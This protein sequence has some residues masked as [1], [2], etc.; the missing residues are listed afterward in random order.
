MSKWS[1]FFVPSLCKLF[2]G[3]PNPH[4]ITLGSAKCRSLLFTAAR[5]SL[6]VAFGT[7]LIAQEPPKREREVEKQYF[8]H[9]FLNRKKIWTS[10]VQLRSRPLPSRMPLVAIGGG[11]ST[12]DSNVAEQLEGNHLFAFGEQNPASSGVASLVGGAAFYLYGRFVEE[13]HSRET[14]VFASVGELNSI[15]VSEG[16]KLATGRERPFE[17]A[18]GRFLQG[19]SSFP[20]NHPFLR[21]TLASVLADEYP[22]PRVEMAPYGTARAVSFSRIANSD[23]FPSDVFVGTGRDYLRGRQVYT[24]HRDEDLHGEDLGKFKKDET[25]PPRATGATYVPMDSWVYPAF[26]RLSAMGFVDTD[27]PSLRPWTRAECARLVREVSENLENDVPD[28]TARAIYRELRQ[29]FLPEI[30]GIEAVS[31]SRIEDL[32]VRAGLL[33]G[34]PIADDYHFA[35]TII[36]DF[37]RPFGNGANAIAGFSSRTVGGPFAMYVRGEYQHAGTLPPESPALLQAIANADATPFAVPSRTGSLDRFRFLDSYVSLNLRNNIIAFGKQTLWWGAG[38]DAPFLFSNNAEP[39]PLLRL[40][41]ATPVFLPS[42][43]QY[44]GALRFEAVWGQL[45]GHNFIALQNADTSNVRVIGPPIHPHPYLHGEKFSFKPTRNFEFAFSLTTLFGGPG[46]PLTLGNLARSYGAANAAAGSPKDPGDRRSAFDFSYRL[47]G[48]RDWL[49]LYGDSFTEDEFSPV[50]YPRK[51][52]F[53][54]GLY[55][56]KLPK[57]SQLDL[58]IEGVY[59]DIPNLDFGQDAGTEYFNTRFRSGYTNFGQIIGSWIGR[60]GRG[61]SGYATY[62]FSAQS[63]IGIHYRNEQVNQLFIHGGHLQDFEVSATFARAGGLDFGG[64]L[65]LEH[66][67]F[68]VI[69]GTPKFN[70]TASLEIRYQPSQGWRLW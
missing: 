35:E 65:Q 3:S 40:S 12:T 41:R 34:Q 55:M 50:S 49:T 19:S 60:E 33:S 42:I 48:L 70:T 54:G 67:A 51:S 57:A 29:E 11:L 18:R 21:R 47:P 43:F 61:I 44:L 28:Q 20:S 5:V 13:D 2:F 24:A 27:I 45:N 10:P 58:R 66:W 32:Y 8:K 6:L 31:Q 59:T 63:N 62:H 4:G 37:G 26:D 15:L 22:R 14:G 36:D 68:P 17:N 52:S 64:S 9:L 25:F 53:R 38:T 39:L 30:E 1:F 23:H 16:L 56:P 46:Y 69:S 7:S